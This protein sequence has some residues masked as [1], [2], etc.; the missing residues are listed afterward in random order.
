MSVKRQHGFTLVELTI[1]MAMGGVLL[2]VMS[3]GIIKLFT[4][5][6]AGV[7][8]R[9][10]Q[11]TARILSDVITRDIRASY[12]MGTIDDSTTKGLCLMTTTPD[13]LG[14]AN[15]VAYYYTKVANKN[16]TTQVL[17]KTT[18]TG[19]QRS[20]TGSYGCAPSGG[21]AV[22]PDTVSVLDFAAT[23]TPTLNTSYIPQL[24]NYTLTL[25]GSNALDLINAATNTCTV[26]AGSQ[27]CSVTTFQTSVGLLE[28]QP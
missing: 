1:A 11:Q 2:L 6:Q 7:S 16:T 20:A 28:A 21:V 24:V 3:T 15:G 17:K 8:I 19:A 12:G 26:Q 10:S 18:I 9:N 27:Y 5:Y 4:V 22:S 13:T 25:V 14:K 23:P